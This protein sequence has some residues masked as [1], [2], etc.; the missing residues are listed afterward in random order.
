LRDFPELHCDHHWALVSDD[1]KHPWDGPFV[2][3]GPRYH[4]SWS[5]NHIPIAAIYAEELSFRA[6]VKDSIQ[7][8]TISRRRMVDWLE[9]RYPPN[10]TPEEEAEFKRLSEL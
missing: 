4:T 5:I 10:H 6:A 8:G 7:K 9:G 1:I 2:R 3:I